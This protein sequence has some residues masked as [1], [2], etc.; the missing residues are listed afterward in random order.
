MSDE[1]VMASR[2]GEFSVAR[3][4]PELREIPV[5]REFPRLKLFPP[6][7]RETGIS[8]KFPAR[9]FLLNIAALQV[10]GTVA[11]S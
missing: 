9:G 10:H 2:I 5:I 8:R 7:S 4:F 3:K 6:I 11:P 1:K